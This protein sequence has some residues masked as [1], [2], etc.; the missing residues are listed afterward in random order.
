VKEGGKCFYKEEYFSELEVEGVFGE[1]VFG[2]DY[3]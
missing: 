2:F 3:A 1:V